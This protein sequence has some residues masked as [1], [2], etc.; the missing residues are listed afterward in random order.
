V[1]SDWAVP[2][3]YPIAECHPVGIL[4]SERLCYIKASEL[5]LF[6]ADFVRAPPHVGKAEPSGFNLEVGC[7][8]FWNST[9]YLKPT[10]VTGGRVIGCKQEACFST[11]VTRSDFFQLPIDSATLTRNKENNLGALKKSGYLRCPIVV[12]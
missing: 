11:N 2:E 3:A 6:N 7:S 8:K 9:K 1:R 5:E 10:L 12:R 4:V